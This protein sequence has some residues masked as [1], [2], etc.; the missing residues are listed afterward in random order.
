MREEIQVEQV[1]AYC[2][3]EVEVKIF[4]QD[5]FHWIVTRIDMVNPHLSKAILC[6]SFE[7]AS[8]IFDGCV[9]RVKIWKN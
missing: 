6:I 8:E 5:D 7:H 9:D 1:M 3:P 2:L 4:K